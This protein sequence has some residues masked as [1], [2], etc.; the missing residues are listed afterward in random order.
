MSSMV[1]ETVCTRWSSYKMSILTSPDRGISDSWIQ[2]IDI[3]SD[4][5]PIS[6]LKEGVRLWSVNLVLF[7]RST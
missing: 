4:A 7:R 3:S 2:D 6:T 5:I 1:S